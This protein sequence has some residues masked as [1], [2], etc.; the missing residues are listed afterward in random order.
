MEEFSTLAALSQSSDLREEAKS[1]LDLQQK[2]I[3]FSFSKAA[4]KLVK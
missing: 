2:E 4:M 3:P 1:S